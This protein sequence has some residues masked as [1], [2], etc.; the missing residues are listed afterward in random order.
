MIIPPIVNILSKMVLCVCACVYVCVF[1]SQASILSFKISS[2]TTLGCFY[3]LAPVNSATMNIH[4]HSF[5]WTSVFFYHGF[6][7]RSGIAGSYSSYVRS[8]WSNCQDVFQNSCTI[9]HSH[10]QQMRVLISPPPPCQYGL[11]SVFSAG[12]K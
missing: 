3:F 12:V 9:L 2:K 4:V 1:N 10:Q 7:P 8:L 11:L 6:T 5:V